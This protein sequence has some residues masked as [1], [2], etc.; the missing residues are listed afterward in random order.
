MRSCAQDQESI[1][2]RF[3]FSRPLALSVAT[4]LTVKEAVYHPG[5]Q[6]LPLHKVHYANKPLQKS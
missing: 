2:F 5:K 3:D 1:A 6:L 4:E